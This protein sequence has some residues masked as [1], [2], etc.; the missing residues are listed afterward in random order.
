T[1]A[2]VG[3]CYGT[4][5]CL[6]ARPVRPWPLPAGTGDFFAIDMAEFR[7]NEIY[8]SFVVQI[9]RG[10]DNHVPGDV[11]RRGGRADS[12]TGKGAA[13]FFPA[14]NGETQRM[15][16]VNALVEVVVDEVVRIVFNILELLEDDRFFLLHF[17]RIEPGGL[18]ELR[19]DIDCAAQ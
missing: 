11:V 15:F 9:S 5:D 3:L 7:A 6:V 18:D 16:M 8:H 19:K 10:R 2:D 4:L 1:H 14:D 12:I 17:H 13:R